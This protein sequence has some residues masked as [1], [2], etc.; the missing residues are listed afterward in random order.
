ML[1]S[2]SQVSH[3]NANCNLTKTSV[4]LLNQTVL[5]LW[6]GKRTNT[7]LSDAPPSVWTFLTKKRDLLLISRTMVTSQRL[8]IYYSLPLTLKLVSKS[9]TSN[10]HVT[11][12]QLNLFLKRS[13]TATKSVNSTPFITRQK[14]FVAPPMIV[15]VSE[16]SWLQS[17]CSTTTNENQQLSIKSSCLLTTD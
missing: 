17:R 11:A 13:V 6:G 14:K 3:P 16:L 10:A 15:S 2:A 12:Q 1:V 9:Q 8:W 7:A 4:S 5:M